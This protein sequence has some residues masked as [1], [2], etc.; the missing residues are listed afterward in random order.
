M[1][2]NSA[3]AVIDASIS[4]CLARA[5]ATRELSM[6]SQRLP[7]CPATYAVLPDP[8]RTEE[9]LGNG[10]RSLC[11]SG[12]LRIFDDAPDQGLPSLGHLGDGM[13]LEQIQIVFEKAYQALGAHFQ[14]QR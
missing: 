14:V 11:D 8:H 1:H 2:S 6:V 12:G 5:S 10:C 9:G 4:F 13:G 7:H 3:L